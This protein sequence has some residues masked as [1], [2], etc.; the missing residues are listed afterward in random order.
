[1]GVIG[2]NGDT[3]VE[4][5][6]DLRAPAQAPQLG[7]QPRFFLDKMEKCSI[8]E[9]PPSPYSPDVLYSVFHQTE[10]TVFCFFFN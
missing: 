9:L 2:G 3:C 7:G 1:M 8:G 4:V 10:D 5:L 6:A